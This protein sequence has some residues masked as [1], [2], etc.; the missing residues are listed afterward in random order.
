MDT[1]FLF[2]KYYHMLSCKLENNEKKEKA[3]HAYPYSYSIP[4]LTKQLTQHENL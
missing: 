4:P 2:E 3:L 1:I